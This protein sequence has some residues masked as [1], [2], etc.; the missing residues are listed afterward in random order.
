MHGHAKILATPV[1]RDW[2]TVD[3]VKVWQATGL[4][5]HM[6]PGVVYPPNSGLPA[7]VHLTH[8]PI[9]NAVA[10]PAMATM[11]GAPP[12]LRAHQVAA[13]EYI[14]S[15]RG[16]LLADEQRVGKTASIM[17]G[18]D[19]EAGQLV[20][21][22]PLAAR[23]VWHEWASRRF[24]DC[25]NAEC[26]ICKRLG[27]ETVWRIKHL[28]GVSTPS[29]FA[30]SGRSLDAAQLE[31]A[32]RA[33]VI[34]LHFAV[35]PTWRALFNHVN[36]GTLVVDECHLAG[37]QNRNS[38]YI[39]S[40]RFLNTVAQR[41]VFASGTPL[42][43]KPRG[44]WP[45]LD[46]ITPGAFGGFW[47]FARRYCDAKPGAYGWTAAGA[48]NTEELKA[49]LA[50]VMLRRRWSDIQAS[51]PPLNRAIEIVPLAQEKI[52]RVE[53]VAA[54]IRS[55]GGSTKTVVG[56]LSR[57]RKLYAQEKVQAALVHIG[58][59]LADGN[60]VIAWTWHKEV[61]AS[62]AEKL[63]A[64]GAR[65]VGPIDGDTHP[66]EREKLIEEARSAPAPLV[67]VASMAALAT[68][69][70]LSFCSH[71]IFVEL[72][73][74]PPNIAQAEMRPYDGKNAISITYLVADCEV[75]QKLV[76]ALLSKLSVMDKLGL[77]AGAGSV[78]AVLSQSLDIQSTQTLAALCAAV[79][80]E[81]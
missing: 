34:F 18:H 65:V 10:P 57:L 54:R 8:L 50:Q 40:L 62:L 14:R 30:L 49:R 21:I 7:R 41:A 27:A 22:G 72:D 60:N 42:Y 75:E 51:L 31:E 58:N 81:A 13:V 17:W 3:W 56:D 32:K 26:S 5:P 38:V 68:A 76:D 2:Y 25:G 74:N 9:I 4:A 23:A 53:E 15:R 11:H 66:D 77:D 16:T 55:Q 73:W 1:G 35:I 70:N 28:A 29:F 24:G 19:H 6:I 69:V 52:D 64:N 43:N 78:Q 20:V 67:I 59:T 36:I 45:I 47:D 46:I 39:E 79:L 63:R 61:A 48:S 71:A 37:I 44:L 33:R 12:A 80:E